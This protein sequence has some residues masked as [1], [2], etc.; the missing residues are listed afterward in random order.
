[1]HFVGRRQVMTLDEALTRVE[2]LLGRRLE[3]TEIRSFLPE[4]QDGEYR[5]SA[6][7]S[8]FV[9]ALELARQGKL[10]LDQQAAFE[11]LYIRAA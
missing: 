2:R 10:Q 5:R 9:A 11:P 3:W 1:V 6:L 8:S 4:T 7:A